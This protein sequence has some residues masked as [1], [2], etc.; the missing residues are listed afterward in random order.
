MIDM[1]KIFSKEWRKSVQPRKQRKYALNAPKHLKKDML[2]AHLSDPLKK[3][4]GKRSVPV[5]SGDTVKIMRGNHK[6]KEGKV[7]AVSYKEGHIHVSAASYSKGDGSTAYYP[8]RPSNV[9]VTE[10]DLSDP[11][12][13]A[14]LEPDEVKK[15]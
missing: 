12:R 2:S 6:G 5:R 10:F 4:H 1:A 3:R 9:M 15:K 8:I 11:K 13:K 14:K 7:Q